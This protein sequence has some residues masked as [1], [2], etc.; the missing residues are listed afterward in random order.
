M[1][2]TLGLQIT[3]KP[4]DSPNVNLGDTVTSPWYFCEKTFLTELPYKVGISP[5]WESIV[6]RILTDNS[7]A[8]VHRS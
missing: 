3:L 1:S 7:A 6:A 2:A 4:T 8:P 5:N